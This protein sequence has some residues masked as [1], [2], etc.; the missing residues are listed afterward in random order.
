[1]QQSRTGAHGPY[2]A[3]HGLFS[4]SIQAL[5]GLDAPASC[6]MEAHVVCM[7]ACKLLAAGGL[8]AAPCSRRQH[9][10]PGGGWLE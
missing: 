6:R 4:T 9:L 10:M 2:A 1:M 8:P 3:L 5:L 7:L